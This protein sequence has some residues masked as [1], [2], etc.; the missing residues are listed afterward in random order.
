TALCSLLAELDLK[1]YNYF[2]SFRTSYTKEHQEKLDELP[3]KLGIFPM[4]SEM[5]MDILTMFALM[6]KMKGSPSSWA[7]RRVHRAYRREWRKHFGGTEF[8]LVIHYNGYEAYVISLLEEAPCPKIIWVHSD[9]VHEIEER[10]N[11]NLYILREAYNVYD[12][13]VTVSGDVVDPVIHGIGGDPSRVKVIPSCHDH[14]KVLALAERPL[15]FEPV[16]EST[17]S[18]EEVREILDNKE[19][20]FISIGRFSPEKGHKRLLD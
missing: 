16:T 11:Q 4:G 1:K 15:S 18:L 7:E 20:K 9:M 19:T 13:V 14:K 2:L 17:H 12:R 10:G 5:N 3:E 6:R 8:S